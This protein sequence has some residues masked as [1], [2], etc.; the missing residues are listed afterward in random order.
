[1]TRIERGVNFGIRITRGPYYSIQ[2]SPAISRLVLIARNFQDY[3]SRHNVSIALI[4]SFLQVLFTY[5]DFW[6]M[7]NR[8]V[9]LI[10]RDFF[11]CHIFCS[12]LELNEDVPFNIV[13][14][15]SHR[16][17]DLLTWKSPFLGSEGTDLYNG[18][19]KTKIGFISM[20]INSHY[21]F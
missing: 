8:I 5:D 13:I 19:Q 6:K 7:L 21:E 2:F 16:K 10:D 17:S 20:K 15:L 12:S 11:L 1:M 9:Y 18:A 3:S 14:D 4:S